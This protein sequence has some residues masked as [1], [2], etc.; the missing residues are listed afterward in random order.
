MKTSTQSPVQSTTGHY[1]TPESRNARFVL[2]NP[3]L[4][5]K[6]YYPLFN[7]ARMMSAVTPELKGDL[8]RSQNTFHSPPMI[9]EDLIN[10][11]FSRNCWWVPETGSPWS[12]TGVS[13]EVQLRRAQGQDDD[14]ELQV[15]PGTFEVSR[16]H[17][18]L[19][20]QVRVFVPSNNDLCEVIIF[21]LTNTSAQPIRGTLVPAIPIYARS[22]DNQ[23]DHRQVTTLLNR[24]VEIPGGIAVKPV[25]TFDERGHRLNE[26]LYSVQAFAEN[27]QTAP[28]YRRLQDF[29]GPGGSLE[30]PQAVY[31]KFDPP[32]DVFE[33]GREAIAAFGFSGIEIQPGQSFSISVMSG[34]TENEAD[35]TQWQSRY[36]TLDKAL[37]NFHET[38]HFWQERLSTVCYETGD[39]E[40]DNWMKWVSFQPMARKVFGCS[41][42]PDFGYGRGGR[43]WRDLWQDCLALV[44]TNPAETTELL[45]HNFAGVRADGSNATII[46]ANPGEFVAD[47]NAISRTWMDHGVW[48]V[49][50]TQLYLDQSGDIDFLLRKQRYFKDAQSHRSKSK[51][52]AWT[53]SQGN[54]LKTA[55]NTEYEGSILEHMLIQTVTQFYNVG[56]HGICKLEDADWNDGLD[57]AHKRGESVAFHCMFM[58]NLLL[59]AEVLELIQTQ[60]GRDSI[61]IF[62]EAIPL[63]EKSINYGNYDERRD[64][65][66][67]YMTAVSHQI[68]GEIIQVNIPK[69][70]ADL[71]EKAAEMANV[72]RQN[73]W[74]QV[75]NAKWINGYYDNDGQ[76]VEGKPADTVR[77]TLTG[78]VFP[79]MSGLLN[80]AEIDQ[81][82]DAANQH[83][84]DPKLKGYRLNTDF[85]TPQMNLGRAFSFSY[86]DKENGAFFS[87][88]IVMFMAAFYMRGD[89]EKGYNVFKSIY[90]MSR[91]DSVSQIL[92]GIPEYIDSEGR[93]AYLYLTGSASWMVLTVAT[94]M[95]GIRGK[96]GK[97]RIYPKLTAAQLESGSASILTFWKGQRLSVT[98]SGTTGSRNT[99]L[100]I[101]QATVNATQMDLNNTSEEWIEIEDAQLFTSDGT[102]TKIE[103]RLI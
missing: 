44:L 69:L 46:G 67:R 96:W 28:F 2:S 39:L 57:M 88:M 76:K 86:G 32:S 77:M 14:V 90:D 97:L 85:K 29:V 81:V 62:K 36:A 49:L 78:Q 58:H 93:G 63:F 92:P 101:S 98:V 25:M 27:G 52:A 10:T 8:K 20:A 40:F 12:L 74:V 79:I 19:A 66:N 42:L 7:D 84:F 55:A 75:G 89:A 94:Q 4:R 61:A 91:N 38:Q 35:F 82:F 23:R 95:F 60:K 70:A 51:D 65:L 6:L 53:P 64:A 48:P 13:A 9:T 15:Q 102:P 83:L 87:H 72:V 17:A 59:L 11:K 68:S 80:P 3:Q 37:L 54:W 41:F 103:L 21:T 1:A 34:I 100:K 22:A 56:D 71:R 33:D 47:R 18:G 16:R 43:G 45:Y 5:N 73:E 24:L 26:L 99:R 30:A 31:G 50:T